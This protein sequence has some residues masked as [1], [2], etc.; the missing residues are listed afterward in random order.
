ML[1][2]SV[3]CSSSDSEGPDSIYLMRLSIIISQILIFIHSGHRCLWSCDNQQR[4]RSCLRASQGNFN[5]GKWNESKFYWDH[6]FN[7]FIFLLCLC[8]SMM[9]HWDRF[10]CS[11]QSK[12]LRSPL[13]VDEACKNV[14]SII[15][16][17][18]HM[19]GHKSLA[20]RSDKGNNMYHNILMLYDVLTVGR[21][22]I[23]T[24]NRHRT[25]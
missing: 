10:G 11:C 23:S 6:S 1:F 14:Q 24:I 19:C 2:F 12:A 8:Q 21:K 20:L 25:S 5:R 13:M 7:S 4:I 15:I 22:A 9:H 3:R 17:I 16:P 18:Y